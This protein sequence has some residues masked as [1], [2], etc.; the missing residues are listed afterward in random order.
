MQPLKAICLAAAVDAVKL[1]DN[2]EGS[3]TTIMVEG[4]AGPLNTWWGEKDQ[5]AVWTEEDRFNN[6]EEAKLLEE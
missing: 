2:N 3:L 5:D 4:Q 1:N 6:T